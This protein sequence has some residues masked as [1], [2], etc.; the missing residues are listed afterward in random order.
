M[1]GGVG[2]ESK[3]GERER[4]RERAQASREW[5]VKEGTKSQEGQ[6]LAH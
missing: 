4:E 2:E 3:R 5:T 1:K 6:E